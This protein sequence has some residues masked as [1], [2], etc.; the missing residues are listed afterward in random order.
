MPNFH[1]SSL[2]PLAYPHQEGEVLFMWEATSA[3]ESLVL[4]Q[5]EN[6]QFFIK[7]IRRPEGLLVKGEK[8]TRPSQVK[9]LQK[10]LIAYENASQAAVRFSNIYSTKN[11]HENPSAHLKPPAFFAETFQETREIWVEVG[12]GS[13][14]HLLHQAASNPT[15]LHVGIEIHKPSVEQVLKRIEHEGLENVVVVDYD[16][17]ILMEFLPANSVGRIFVHFP[18]PWDKKPHRRVISEGFVEEAL[19]V[20]KV[21]GTL[22]LRTD[23]DAYYAYALDVFMALSQTKVQIQKNM[24][25]AVSSKYED[26]W[27]RMEKNI[28]DLT[29]VNQHEHAPTPPPVALVFEA[30]VDVAALRHKETNATLRG[31][32]WFVHVEGWYEINQTQGM[33]KVAFGAYDRPEHRYVVIDQENAH[34]FPEEVFST[35][36]NTLAHV[37]LTEWMNR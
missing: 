29:L 27:K 6:H 23:S 22:E 36:A 28:Y 20:L 32:T 10:G 26:R 8:I 34:Y 33:L 5:L 14:R 16:A 3:D 7:Q 9:V 4:A 24:D 37:A 35:K 11:H 31:E 13:G 18:I 17:R 30:P 1:A 2:T 19:R 25:L 21:G 12:F 15:V